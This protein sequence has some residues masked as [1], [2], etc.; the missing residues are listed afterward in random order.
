[1]FLECASANLFE[2]F[3]D[4]FVRLGRFLHQDVQVLELHIVLRDN[5][6]CYQATFEKVI[7]MLFELHGDWVHKVYCKRIPI[8]INNY[9][10]I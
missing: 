10:V 7:G 9:Q 1:M 5:N 8:L 3:E 2:Y 6:S 4:C